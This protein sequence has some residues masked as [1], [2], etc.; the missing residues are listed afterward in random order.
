ML[1][2]A[3]RIHP[4]HH[5]RGK[6]EPL[7]AFEEVLLIA[8]GSGIAAIVPYIIDHVRRD[9]EGKTKTK[10]ITLVWADRKEEYVKHLVDGPL[11]NALA[12]EDVNANIYI[13]SD[14]A[15]SPASSSLAVSLEKP[16]PNSPEKGVFAKETQANLTTPRS[17]D[18]N[19]QHGRP[20]VKSIIEK[21]AASV[22]ESQSKLAIFVCGPPELADETRD[23][24]YRSMDG[25][26]DSVQ[27][28]EEAFGW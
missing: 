9:A 28:F 18:P 8:G 25:R 26:S 23:A 13:T 27:Y 10:S 12:R 4:V 24:T 2:L 7:W 22:S 19:I 16:E 3:Q 5:S 14:S 21:V 17:K 20:N 6:S 15:R 11:S 1:E